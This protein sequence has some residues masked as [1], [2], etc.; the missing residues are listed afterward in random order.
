MIIDPPQHKTV[1]RLNT[2]NIYE[3]TIMK[4]VYNIEGTKTVIVNLSKNLGFFLI[5]F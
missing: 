1:S 3:K 5:F 2:K 4:R